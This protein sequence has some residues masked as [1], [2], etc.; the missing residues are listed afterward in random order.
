MKREVCTTECQL[1][2]PWRVTFCTPLR[3]EVIR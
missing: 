3:E 1:P 2:A